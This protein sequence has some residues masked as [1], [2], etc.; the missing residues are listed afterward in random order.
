MNENGGFEM[1]VSFQQHLRGRLYKKF[2]WKNLKK[3][4]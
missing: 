3:I 2:W 1:R 4:P